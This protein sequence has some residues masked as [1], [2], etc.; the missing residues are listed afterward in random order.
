MQRVTSRSGGR[1]L[2]QPRGSSLAGSAAAK[3]VPARTIA[4]SAAPRLFGPVVTRRALAC[5]LILVFDSGLGGLTV[6]GEIA[7]ARPD[8]RLIYAADDAVF[9]YGALDETALIA[10]VTAVME[11]LIAANRPDLVVVACNTASTLVLPALRARFSV[12]FVGTVP[13]IKP[14]CAASATKLVSVLGTE[15]TVRREYT[16]A[17]IR[18]FATGCDVTLVGSARL[19]A[20]AESELRGEEVADAEIAAEI[21]PCFVANGTRRT[22]TIVLACTHYPLLLG[23]MTR[24]APWAVEFLDP[25]AAIARRVVELVGPA[26]DGKAAPPARAIFTAGR[27]VSPPLAAALGRFGIARIEAGQFDTPTVSA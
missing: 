16:H 18:E 19:A 21:A 5:P 2:E 7:R 14:A 27:A 17:L 20:L 24:L 1:G 23:R 11:R 4:P 12:P 9:P 22:D 26:R 10:R 13:A 15:A 8:A 3:L 25:A 6:Y